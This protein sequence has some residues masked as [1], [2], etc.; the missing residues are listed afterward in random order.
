MRGYS[1]T[2]TYQLSAYLYSLQ[3]ALTAGSAGH[4]QPKGGSLRGRILQGSSDAT[5]ATSYGL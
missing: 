2:R 5:E 1:L 4:E 3:L